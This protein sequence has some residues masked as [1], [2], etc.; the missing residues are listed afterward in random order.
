MSQM[1]MPPPHDLVSL[2]LCGKECVMNGFIQNRIY[3]DL[4]HVACQEHEQN[5]LVRITS[6]LTAVTKW[7]ASGI[8]IRIYTWLLIS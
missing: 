3:V 1:E 4:H 7:G 2:C 8:E 5:L 6:S